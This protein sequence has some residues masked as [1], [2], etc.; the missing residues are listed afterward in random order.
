[1]VIFESRPEV[2]INIAAL[3]LALK[4][5]ALYDPSSL[6]PSHILF[7]HHTPNAQK[8]AHI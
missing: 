3:T 5:G 6:S 2:I 4:S 7:L 1:V 8:K